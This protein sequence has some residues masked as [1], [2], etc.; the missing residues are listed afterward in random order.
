[1]KIPNTEQENRNRIAEILKKNFGDYASEDIEELLRPKP[2]G[3][4]KRVESTGEKVQQQEPILP[5]SDFITQIQPKLQEARSNLRSQITKIVNKVRL[6]AIKAK[7]NIQKRSTESTEASLSD[8]NFNESFDGSFDDSTEPIW[9]TD[10]SIEEHNTGNVI[11][12]SENVGEKDE[13]TGDRFRKHCEHC[14][15]LAKKFPCPSCGSI[16][17]GVSHQQN[18][19]TMRQDESIPYAPSQVDKTSAHLSKPRYVFD[20]QQIAN[21]EQFDGYAQGDDGTVG[22]YHNPNAYGEL[23]HILHENSESLHLQN[24][25]VGNGHLLQPLNLAH[26]SDAI[27]FIQEL[28]QRNNEQTNGDYYRNSYDVGGTSQNYHAKRSFEIVPLAEKDDGSVFVKISPHTE[29][30]SELKNQQRVSGKSDIN[31]DNY[32]KY[33][34]D[35]DV[36]K[37]STIENQF[38]ENKPK[39]N[40]EKFVRGGKK[41]E[42]LALSANGSEEGSVGSDEDMEILKYIYAVNQKEQARENSSTETILE[43]KSTD[44]NV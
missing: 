44:T 30:Q 4:T 32:E 26:A 43:N 14:G 7:H 25:R 36:P 12:D 27:R 19:E 22:S 15:E 21:N 9:I 39:A 33:E 42:I 8:V 24:R 34:G 41:Y 20:R 2:L 35:D 13:P 31:F 18:F 38:V 37:L 1:M 16:P 5:K 17:A 40:F 23:E 6:N 28:T 10:E 11:N 29:Y 3:A